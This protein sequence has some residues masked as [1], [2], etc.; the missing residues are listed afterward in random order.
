[1]STWVGPSMASTIGEAEK[2]KMNE[3]MDALL[4]RYFKTRAGYSYS[5]SQKTKEEQREQLIQNI[6]KAFDALI[7]WDK[8]NNDE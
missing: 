4:L 2:K 6:E 7:E 1:M 8:K 5:L 3:E